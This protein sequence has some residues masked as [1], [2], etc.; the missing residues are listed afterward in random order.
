MKIP[1]I[2]AP[3]SDPTGTLAALKEAVE[4]IS[5]Q[6]RGAPKIERLPTSPTNEALAAK[7]NELIERLQGT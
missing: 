1:G 6:R 5:G 4:I 2:P 3:A 7:I